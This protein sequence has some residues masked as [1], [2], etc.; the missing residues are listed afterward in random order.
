MDRASTPTY[1]VTGCARLGGQGDS[2]PA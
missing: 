1:D 2:N